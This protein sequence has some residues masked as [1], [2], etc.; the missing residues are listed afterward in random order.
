MRRAREQ[1][2]WQAKARQVLEVYRWV[3]GRRPDKPWFGMPV[4]ELDDNEVPTGVG[5]EAG[6]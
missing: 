6:G 4:P 1:F 2:T 5:N 3:T